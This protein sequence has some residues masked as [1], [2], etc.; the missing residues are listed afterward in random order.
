MWRSSFR[1]RNTVLH[2]VLFPNPV[3]HGKLCHAWKLMCGAKA[4]VLM[5]TEKLIEVHKCWTR[6]EEIRLPQFVGRRPQIKFS[7][8]T[9]I[10]Q[11]IITHEQ[12]RAPVYTLLPALQF[13]SVNTV[14]SEIPG[15]G[16]SVNGALLQGHEDLISP[17]VWRPSPGFPWNVKCESRGE[18]TVPGGALSS[19]IY[20]I[21]VGVD[22]LFCMEVKSQMKRNQRVGE[23][24]WIRSWW[25]AWLYQRE[26]LWLD[27]H[28]KGRQTR[29]EDKVKITEKERGGFMKSLSLL[30]ESV[31]F[32]M[33]SATMD[34]RATRKRPFGEIEAAFFFV[35]KALIAEKNNI[36]FNNFWKMFFFFF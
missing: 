22:G 3:C 32:D 18:E 6:W 15:C 2:N 20:F 26:G 31:S 11:L 12:A 33:L 16:N 35:R 29:K 19:F 25:F 34:K 7:Y 9:L 21:A 27:S 30:L 17:A 4:K 10:Y 28:W 23:R 5:D 36:S 24:L 1:N 14:I 8:V 13:C